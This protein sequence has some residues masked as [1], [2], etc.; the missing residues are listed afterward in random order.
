M[1][2]P[3]R[4]PNSRAESG[5][6]PGFERMRANLVARG[7]I[8]AGFRITPAGTAYAGEIIRD[9]RMQRIEAEGA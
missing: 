2:N 8:D 5:T 1:S 3:Y 9:L 4:R 6:Y 7:L